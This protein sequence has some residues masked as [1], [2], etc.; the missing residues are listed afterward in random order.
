MTLTQIKAVSGHRSDAVVQGYIEKSDLQKMLASKALAVDGLQDDEAWNQPIKNSVINPNS[1]WTLAQ[2]TQNTHAPP[3][4]PPQAPHLATYNF[5]FAGASNLGNLTF[6]FSGDS[7][8]S[9]MQAKVDS[10][11]HFIQNSSVANEK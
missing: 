4:A 3:N 2:Q 11:P 8:A 6:T 9:Q 5:N 1:D 7:S 10:G